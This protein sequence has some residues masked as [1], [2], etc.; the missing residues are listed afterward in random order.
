MSCWTEMWASL[1][2]WEYLRYTAS[3]TKKKHDFDQP[4]MKL[5]HHVSNHTE[6]CVVSPLSVKWIYSSSRRERKC[7]GQQNIPPQ[8]NIHASSRLQKLVSVSFK[9][10]C[11]FEWD[12]HMQGCRRLQMS[13]PWAIW[14]RLLCPRRHPTDED[15]K[16]AGECVCVSVCIFFIFFCLFLAVSPRHNWQAVSLIS[17][18][19]L[20]SLHTAS[21]LFPNTS[22]MLAKVWE[23]YGHGAVALP[24]STSAQ[25]SPGLCR[26]G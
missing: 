2:V 16:W 17:A 1:S 7:W 19:L 6:H 25:T 18:Q 22:I 10:V 15:S 9:C 8:A 26:G 11:V 4:E 23:A 14:Q 5:L 12:A 13:S 3:L 20:W 21:P 24:D